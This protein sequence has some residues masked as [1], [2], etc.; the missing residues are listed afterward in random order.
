MKNLTDLTH[1]YNRKSFEHSEVK[2]EL[3]TRKDYWSREK[4][5]IKRR[6]KRKLWNELKELK[7][8]IELLQK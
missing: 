1:E 3:K 7:R 2:R 6:A 4:L 5:L 8:E